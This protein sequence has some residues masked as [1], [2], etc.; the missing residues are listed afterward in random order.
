MTIARL[1]DQTVVDLVDRF[2]NVGLAQYDALARGQHAKFRQLFQQ[3]TDISN[4]LKQRDGDQRRALL[5][6]YD[7]NNMQVRLKAAIHTLAI[8]PDQARRALE[9]IAASKWY[10]QAADAG[11]C[12]MGLDQG[13]Y[14]PT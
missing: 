10:P 12:L 8:A 1:A 2:A 4:E 7:Y 3:M 13:D 11:F 9:T 5:K 14:K 6:L